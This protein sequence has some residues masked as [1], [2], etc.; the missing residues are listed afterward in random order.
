MTTIARLSA[1][2]LALFLW[3]AN[4]HADLDRIKDAAEAGNA[5]SQLELGILYEYGFN[6]KGKNQIP[7]LT[8]YMISADQGVA[9]AAKLRDALQAKLTAAEVQQ[10]RDEAEK[11]K[12]AMKFSPPPAP[13]PA[14]APAVAEEP[15][16]APVPVTETPA[17]AP[18]PAPSA[19]E[20]KP[21]APVAAPVT[22]IPAAPAP[23]ASAPAEAKPATPEEPK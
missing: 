21:A 3:Q 7:A 14:A 17:A 1:I 18:A 10:A 4:A 8:W 15:K 9:K 13:K 22:T 2:F 20:V 16:L 12:K 5:E 19:P 11:L 23:A 6:Y